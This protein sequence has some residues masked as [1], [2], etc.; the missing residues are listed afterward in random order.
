VERCLQNL[1]HG[2]PRAT[3]HRATMGGDRVVTAS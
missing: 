3:Q 1:F 2:P